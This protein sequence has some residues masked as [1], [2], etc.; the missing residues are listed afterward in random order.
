MIDLT[1]FRSAHDMGYDR[2]LESVVAD[3][4][5]FLSVGVVV[6]HLKPVILYYIDF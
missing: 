6:V 3:A 2:R 5:S 4:A 1:D